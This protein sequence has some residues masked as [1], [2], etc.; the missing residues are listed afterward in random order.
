MDPV[1]Q[2]VTRVPLKATH[3]LVQNPVLFDDPDAARGPMGVLLN[4]I[5]VRSSLVRPGL[6]CLGSNGRKDTEAHGAT[7]TV[8]GEAEVGDWH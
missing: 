2:R 4:A 6:A 1:G 8:K 7:R 5:E 3:L